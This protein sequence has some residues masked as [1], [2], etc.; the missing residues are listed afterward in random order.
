VFNIIGRDAGDEG[1]I[2]SEGPAPATISDED[3]ARL[4][5]DG[6]MARELHQR[7]QDHQ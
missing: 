5:P 3:E 1:P 4:D 6:P 7:P 2:F